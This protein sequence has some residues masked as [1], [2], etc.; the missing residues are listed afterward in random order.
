MFPAW[1]EMTWACKT[2]F[3]TTP[4]LNPCEVYKIRLIIVHNKY[5]RIDFTETFAPVARLE[6]IHILILFT[7][8]HNTRLHQMNVKCIFLNVF[9]KQ[10]SD[11]ESDLFLNHVFKLK[12][13]LYRLKQAPHAWYEK[14]SSFLIKNDDII[15]F[16]TNDSLYGGF[17]KLM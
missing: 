1:A 15:F 14:L 8:H 5:K 3:L 11:F 13:T 4:I 16:A 2:T 12:N 17:S 7:A 10:P 9:V 6:V